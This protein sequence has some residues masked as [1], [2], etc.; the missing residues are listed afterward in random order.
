MEVSDFLT[1][2]KKKVL[3]FMQAATPNELQLMSNCSKKKVDAIIASRPFVGWI[4][5]VIMFL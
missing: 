3:D 5:L 1:N 2:D 4:D